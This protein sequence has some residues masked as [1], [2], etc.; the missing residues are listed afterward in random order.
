ML[1]LNIHKRVINTK[2]KS[3]KEEREEKFRKMLYT[4]LMSI[5]YVI[6]VK[7]CNIQNPLT[8]QKIFPRMY[9]LIIN[10]VNICIYVICKFQF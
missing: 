1:Q 3:Y 4:I 9:L 2:R 5:L 6:Y 10:A 7:I 8:R